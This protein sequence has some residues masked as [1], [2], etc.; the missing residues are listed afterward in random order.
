M[1]SAPAAHTLLEMPIWQ[2]PALSQHPGQVVE[3]HGPAADMHCPLW[4]IPP[5]VVQS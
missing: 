4:Q 3:S 5:F 2:L 1:P